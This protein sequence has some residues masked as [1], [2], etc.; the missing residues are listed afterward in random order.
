LKI[1]HVI[2]GLQ[3]GGAET[4]LLKLLKTMDGSRFEPIVVS[5]Q[6]GGATR[7]IMTAEGVSV[8]SLGLTG[9][10]TTPGAIWRLR[11]L[12]RAL[13]PQVIQGWMY[14]GN[15][16]A[17]LMAG[18]ARGNPDVF[19]NIRHSVYDLTMEKPLV[20][21]VIR[22]GGRLSGRPRKIVFNSAVSLEQHVGLGYRRGKCVMIPNGFDTEAFRPDP[23]CRRELRRELDLDQDTPILGSVGRMHPHKGQLDFLKAAARVSAKRPEVHFVMAGEGVTE[24][25]SELRG[26]LAGKGLRQQVHLLGPR[27]DVPCLMAGLDLLCISSLTESFPN[28]LGEAMACGVPCV[29]TNVGEAAR[30]IG[31]A[32]EIVPPGQP[33]AL[34]G[35]I[36]RVLALPPASLH[37]LGT[38]ARQRIV[39][40]Y[41]IAALYRKYA[42]LYES[43]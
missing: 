16:G 31:T 22:L 39:T 27:S 5:L 34:A 25:N 33:D 2:T 3:V 10:L 41:S 21:M 13:E 4:M 18:L 36:I 19:W 32:G 7:D 6:D 11:R 1:V 40:H 43:P 35:G 26:F 37:A 42:E 20:R 8:R 28:V 29:A 30:I 15:L 23:A 9:G 17:S 38:V 24:E 14:H 12:A